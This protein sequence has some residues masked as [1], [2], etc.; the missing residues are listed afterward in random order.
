MF[1]KTRDLIFDEKQLSK[2]LTAINNN[3][4]CPELRVGNCGWA[5]QPKKWFVLFHCTNKD[6]EK[7]INQLNKEHI[8]YEE[9]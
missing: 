4:T 7:I 5:N 1:K 2:I 3:L 6:Y 9:G 8:R